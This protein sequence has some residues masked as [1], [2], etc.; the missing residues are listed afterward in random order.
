MT[1]KNSTYICALFAAILFSACSNDNEDYNKIPIHKRYV[2]SIDTGDNIIHI[3][4]DDQHRIIRYGDKRL[5]YNGNTVQV[6]NSYL[7]EIY[8]I[9]QLNNEGYVISVEYEHNTYEHK[10]IDTYNYDPTGL[11]ISEYCANDDI[12]YSFRWE[13]GNRYTIGSTDRFNYVYRDI[14]TTHKTP[15]CNLDFST[16]DTWRHCYG[17]PFG[18]QCSNLIEVDDL[19]SINSDYIEGYRFAYEYDKD[20]YISKIVETWYT[21]GEKD[22]TRVYEITY[23]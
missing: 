18:K 9:I 2:K 11:L 21:N 17:L 4:Y 19:Y 8:A 16:R 22:E 14:Y 7:S 20:G 5:I 15:P 6:I 1:M 13:N 23:Y 3:E 12:G 10:H